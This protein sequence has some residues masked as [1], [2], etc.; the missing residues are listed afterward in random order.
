MRPACEPLAREPKSACSRYCAGGLA[1]ALA[2][3]GSS[4]RDA[5]RRIRRTSRSDCSCRRSRGPPSPHCTDST[6]RIS[7]G[8]DGSTPACAACATI[9]VRRDFER[10]AI[11]SVLELAVAPPGLQC[12]AD[13]GLVEQRLRMQRGASGVGRPA[14]LSRRAG[15]RAEQQG[16]RQRQQG[17]G[18]D[19]FDQGVAALAVASHRARLIHILLP[20]AGEGGAGAGR[21]T[22]RS[23]T[24]HVDGNAIFIGG[25]PA[26]GASSLRRSTRPRRRSTPR[27]GC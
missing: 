13:A 6:S 10:P 5:L 16:Q 25:P 20:Q 15:Q 27:L 23:A 21:D 22:L 24:A 4:Q 26:R 8:A 11:T 2:R 9:D 17:E 12:F 19:D 14:H 1:Q 3:A 18:D 7:C